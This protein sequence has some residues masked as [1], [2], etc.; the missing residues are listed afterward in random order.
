MLKCSALAAL[1]LAGFAGGAF[2]QTQPSQSQPSQQ[3]TADFGSR[4]SAPAGIYSNA[5]Q[6]T[7]LRQSMNNDAQSAVT[8]DQWRH[9]QKAATL[10][11]ANRCEDAYNM[12]LSE[13]DYRLA[14]NVAGICRA[15]VRE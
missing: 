13:E 12:A 10:I 5:I 4:P 3:S 2:A 15:R 9:A 8:R 14:L 1:I 6:M 7:L 11:K